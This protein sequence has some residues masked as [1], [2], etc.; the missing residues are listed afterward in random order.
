MADIRSHLEQLCWEG[1]LGA[2]VRGL[3]PWT[4]SASSMG[5]VCHYLH[6]WE[7]GGTA[8]GFQDRL[9]L[10]LTPA[11]LEDQTPILVNYH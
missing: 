4:G 9:P 8:L 11:W 6:S 5:M 7:G 3:H 1:G 10:R 2:L